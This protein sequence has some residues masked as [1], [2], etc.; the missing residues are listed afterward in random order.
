MKILEEN[1]G[2]VG[3]QGKWPWPSYQLRQELVNSVCVC[4]CVV[5]HKRIVL[6]QCIRIN[7][8]DRGNSNSYKPPLKMLP[9]IM[10]VGNTYEHFQQNRK[11]IFTFAETF[12]K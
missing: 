4:V 8:K 7:L 12:R 1:S 5:A 2:E 11:S 6:H 3:H 9:T 10:L